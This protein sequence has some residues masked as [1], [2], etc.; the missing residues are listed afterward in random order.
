MPKDFSTDGAIGGWGGNGGTAPATGSSTGGGY[1]ANDWGMNHSTGGS[2]SS[3]PQPSSI[4]GGDA[5]GQW[6]PFGQ[7][8]PMLSSTTVTRNPDGTD[9]TTNNMTGQTRASTGDDLAMGL[10]PP[11]MGLGDVIS[12]SNPALALFGN[13]TFYAD[14]GEVPDSGD[15]S[16]GGGMD[17]LLAMALSSV[18]QGLDYGRKKHGLMQTADAS[19]S[20]TPMIPGNPSESGIPRPQPMPGPLPPT[21]N[22]FG[23][24]QQF[25]ENDQQGDN[26][27]D[28]RG[29][30]PDN[31]AD[32]QETA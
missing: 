19:M 29:G 26:D 16:Q 4:P 7:I 32:D 6:S 25:S 24:R 2:D 17:D 30:I 20:R 28:D 15:G 13:P 14:G 31:D 5:T 23:K 9:T 27:A 12:G 18:D 10:S 11:R 21:S 8:G 3:V 1:Q 22:P